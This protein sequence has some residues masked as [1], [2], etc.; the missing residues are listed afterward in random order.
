MGADT[1]PLLRALLR[2]R[3]DIVLIGRTAQLPLP[4]PL[5]SRLAP[6]VARLAGAAADYLGQCAGALSAR[7]LPPSLFVAAL[8]AAFSAEVVAVREQGL[9]RALRADSAER[10]FF[11]LGFALQ[12]MRQNFKDLKR[13]V[14]DWAAVSSR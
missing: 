14:T 5:Q 2:L 10:F 1:G 11:A 9:T 8:F 6:A 3:H 4:E 13:R 7:R 12:Q